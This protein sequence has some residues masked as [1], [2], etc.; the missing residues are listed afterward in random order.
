VYIFTY[1]RGF[2]FNIKDGKKVPNS[3]EQKLLAQMKMK[4]ANGE[5]MLAIHKWLNSDMGVKLNYSSLRG[6]LV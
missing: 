1:R 6:L 4:K 2:G 3:K 5:S